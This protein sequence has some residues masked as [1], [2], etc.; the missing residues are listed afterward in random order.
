MKKGIWVTAL[1]LVVAT[2][3]TACGQGKTEAE[4]GEALFKQSVLTDQPGCITCHSLEPGKIIVGPSL[5]GIATRASN[6][7]QGMSAEEYLR[8]SIVD[9]NAYLV[10]GFPTDTMPPVWA[11]RLSKTQ[12]DQL[13]AFLMTL[14]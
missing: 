11:D 13:I 8:Q 5:A 9:P 2:L 6:T 12:I 4:K 14:K 7:V 1:L 3:L 10:P